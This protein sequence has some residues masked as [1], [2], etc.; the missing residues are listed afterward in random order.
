ML[1]EE[2]VADLRQ[3]GTVAELSMAV[4][5]DAVPA[6]WHRA[7][8]IKASVKSPHLRR[9]PGL[10]ATSP[11]RTI[12]IG[13]QDVP[14]IIIAE[15]E[16]ILHIVKGYVVPVGRVHHRQ[17]SRRTRRGILVDQLRD[18][19]QPDASGSWLPLAHAAKVLGVSRQTMLYEVQRRGLAGLGD[20]Y[21]DTV[22]RPSRSGD[23][24]A[25][26]LPQMR[27]PPR[28]SLRRDSSRVMHQLSTRCYP[29][30]SRLCGSP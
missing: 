28:L 23:P 17:A 6:R 1:P 2:R 26:R 22:K 4:T 16:S 8:W 3:C 24:A 14:G 11:A 18:R 21:C 9:H 13:E 25:L 5:Q 27:H 19:I 7:D 12:D 10:P 20:G 15:A 30:R 29:G